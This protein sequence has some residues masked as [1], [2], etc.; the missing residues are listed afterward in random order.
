MYK[1]QTIQFLYHIYFLVCFQMHAY[2]I[3]FHQDS[4]FKLLQ[5]IF[6]NLVINVLVC[7]TFKTYIFLVLRY[8]LIN[9]LVNYS[10]VILL[11]SK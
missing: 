6:F 4:F 8:D 2:V 10:I 1:I 11:F 9:C 5:I 7:F 3:I